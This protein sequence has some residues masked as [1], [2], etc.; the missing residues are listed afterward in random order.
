MKS[1]LVS[2]MMPAYNAEAYI[3]QAI[4]SILAQSYPQWE[5]IVVDDGSKDRTAEI[6]STFIDPR[7][8]L[9]QQE[10]G[11]EA[12][13][14]NTALQ[15]MHGEWIAFLDADDAFLPDHLRLAVSTLQE[16]PDL[17]AV[18]TNGYYV[19]SEGKQL[20]TLS[21]KR[22]GPFEG[23]IFEQI[24]RAS[25]VFG[26]PICVVLRHA[27]IAEKGF[28]F[29]PRIII[30][31]DWD[32]LTRVAE[33]ARFGYIDLPTCLYRVHTTNV[34]VRINQ[35][36]RAES[37]AICREKAIHL[38]RF[39]SLSAQTRYYA[40]YDLLVELLSGHPKQQNDV[41][42]WKE[43]GAL[44]PVDQARLMS[45][46]A[47]RE[48]ARGGQPAIAQEW[49]KKS[50]RLDPNNLKALALSLLLGFSPRIYQWVF[51]VRDLILVKG[52]DTSPFGDL[53]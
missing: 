34:T 50:R 48:I 6:V 3:H 46:M 18:Y 39:S 10:N 35:S 5:L 9:V 45:M 47:S 43:F 22:R 7:I 13:A 8:T 21:S 19:N 38:T 27:L 33:F 49:M 4:E 28:Q 30:G 41:L 44:D 20:R 15:H 2:I 40:F 25:D 24:V 12:V 11:G 1:G 51:H 14:R 17:D 42:S 16:R 29:D 32:F 53:D 52:T 26:P 37:L 23:D 31:P 36:K